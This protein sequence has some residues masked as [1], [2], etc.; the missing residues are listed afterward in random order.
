MK[1]KERIAIYNIFFAIFENPN[2]NRNKNEE[3]KMFEIE[4][5]RI[6]EK[7]AQNKL[8]K[9]PWNTVKWLKQKN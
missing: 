5:K 4:Q 7:A 3:K 1:Q 8:G 2:E 9:G 6:N